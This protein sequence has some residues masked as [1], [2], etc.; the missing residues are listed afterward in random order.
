[1]LSKP[2]STRLR[3]AP[4]FRS[5]SDIAATSHANFG[6]QRALAEYQC[7]YRFRSEVPGKSPLR[8]VQGLQIGGTGIRPIGSRL[9][10]HRSSPTLSLKHALQAN[11]SRLSGENRFTLCANAALRVR[12]ILSR[13]L[14][15]AA[16]FL[17]LSS[18]RLINTSAIW[19][20]FSAAPLRRLSDTHHSTSPLS[21]VAS[22]RMRL[23]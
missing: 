8:A 16:F 17:A 5:S 15:Y 10:G 12:V 3:P 22:A 20:A 7:Q 13:G 21:T 18:L 9:F 11:A 19:I 14:P 4:A 1:M 6:K 23:I 2:C